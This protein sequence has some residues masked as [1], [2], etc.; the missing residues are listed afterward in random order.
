MTCALPV[1]G[2]DDHGD[3]SSIHSGKCGLDVVKLECAV[4]TRFSQDS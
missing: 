4:K 3:D 2:D 1:T